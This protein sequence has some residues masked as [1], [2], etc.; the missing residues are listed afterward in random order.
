MFNKSRLKE[1]LTQYKKDFLPN[2]WK[3]EKYKWEAIKCFQDNWDV[4]A[5]DFAA[6]LSKSLAETDNLL[7]SMNNFP[8]G[9]ILGFAKHE[10]EE[11]RAMYLDLFDE[12]K[13]VYDRIHV[14]KTKSAILRDKYGLSLIHI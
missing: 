11:V 4:D 5:A 3:E 13:E 14:F 7:T 2:H 9:M 6:M 12:D 1:I 8:K 10:P